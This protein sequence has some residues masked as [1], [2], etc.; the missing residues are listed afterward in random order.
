MAAHA[1]EQ[2][3]PPPHPSQPLAPASGAT[4]ARPGGRR[5]AGTMLAVGLVAVLAGSAL[6]FSGFTLGRQNALTAGTADELQ[7]EFQP[8][9]EAYGK[10]T[11]DYV[12]GADRKKL[13]EGAIEGMFSSLGDPFSFYM[14]S[15]QYKSSLADL[16][17]EFEGIGAEMTTRDPAGKAGCTP[18]G[19]RCRLLVGRAFQGA[20]AQK[21]GLR[22]DDQITAVDGATLDG[23]S[24][25]E[26]VTRVRGKRGTVVTLT[27]VRGTGPP[28]DLRI[29]RDVVKTEDVA[30]KVLADG[31][32]GYLRVD[33]FSSNAGEDF[34]KQL[35]ELVEDKRLTRIVL[36]LRDDPGG[37]IDQAR[38]IASQFIASG[39]IFYQEYADGHRVAQ[40]AAPGGVAT[41]PGIRVLV[42]VNKGTASASEIV[43]AA[44][45][46]TGRAQLLGEKTFGKGTVQQFWTLG[47]DSGGYRLS[48][49]KWLTPKGRWIHRV[50]LDPDLRVSVPAGS[51]AAGADP[52]LD[53]AVEMLLSGSAVA[54]LSRAA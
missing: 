35:A 25:D 34:K 40:E 27:V 28:F 22:T 1:H 51:T 13:I 43:A 33:G 41:D 36:D 52:V 31:R 48:I 7:G 11:R 45:Q 32:V 12:E 21:A 17:G 50:G 46:D 5:R 24:V 15:E 38:T 10:I 47:E 19:P 9:W 26:T 37:F 20:P 16:A 53:R 39:P 42:L 2:A 6:F 8:F 49:A 54:P 3:P 23:L 14:T 44:L 4:T 30:S 18:I 29:T